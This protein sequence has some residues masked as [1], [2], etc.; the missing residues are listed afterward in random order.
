MARA[1]RAHAAH[2][3]ALDSHAELL[4]REFLIVFRDPAPARDGTVSAVGDVLRRRAGEAVG[5]LG[6]LGLRVTPLSDA[7][8]A[9]VLQRATVPAAGLRRGPSPARRADLDLPTVEIARPF[10]PW[11]LSRPPQTGDDLDH[12]FGFHGSEDYPR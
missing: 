3:Q 10:P 9:D 8:A 12:E 7:E 11:P 4:D 1:A 2:L 5:M 6:P